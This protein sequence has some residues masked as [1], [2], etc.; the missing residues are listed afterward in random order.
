MLLSW[1][2]GGPTKSVDSWF[3]FVWI[4]ESRRI[5]HISLS[6]EG[7]HR[8]WWKVECCMLEKRKEWLLYAIF[9]LYIK[10]PCA[11]STPLCPRGAHWP[12]Y[13]MLR[14][15]L[16]SPVT[17]T[18]PELRSS[19][20]YAVS[21]PCNPEGIAQPWPYDIKPQPCEFL[22]NSHSPKNAKSFLKSRK[23]RIFIIRLYHQLIKNLFFLTRCVIINQ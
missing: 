22:W 3:H 15:R 7:D 20:A 18:D 6:G 17:H 5:S 12:V 9:L 8:R 14:H 16:M 21:T 23:N 2:K 13:S 4:K 10:I 19:D 1:K 11:T